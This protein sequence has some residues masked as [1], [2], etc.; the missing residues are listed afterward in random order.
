LF[1]LLSHV[2]AARAFLGSF[3][4]DNTPSRVFLS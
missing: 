4:L 3:C 1:R 2:R